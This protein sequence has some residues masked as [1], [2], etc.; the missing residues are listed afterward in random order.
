MGCM[1][2]DDDDEYEDMPEWDDCFVESDSDSD[3]DDDIN[4]DV[5]GLTKRQRNTTMQGLLQPR[6]KSGDV[7]T[8]RTKE[9]YRWENKRRRIDKQCEQ[10][11]NV[12]YWKHH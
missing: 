12:D 1:I 7:V 3:S 5:P 9:K 2:W 8:G 10:D 6:L 4:N 11:M